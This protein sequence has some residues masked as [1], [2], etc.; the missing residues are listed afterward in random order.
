MMRLLLPALALALALVARADDDH[1]RARRALERAE[2][3]PLAEILP[4]VEAR[5]EARVIEVEYE[6]EDGRHL[7]E[8]E[9]IAPDG[10][11]LEAYVDAATGEILKVEAEED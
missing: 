11:V 7:Y 10:R 8:F 9:L 6:R 5:L 4:E 3:R 1:E 2:V